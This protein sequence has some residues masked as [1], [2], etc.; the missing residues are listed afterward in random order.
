[1]VFLYGSLVLVYKSYRFYK[2]QIMGIGSKWFKYAFGDNQLISKGI[3]YIY[4]F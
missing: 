2:L 3:D 4:W 1:M